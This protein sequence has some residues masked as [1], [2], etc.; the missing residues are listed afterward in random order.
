MFEKINQRV[1][2]KQLH[3]HLNQNILVVSASEQQGM[4]LVKDIL[5]A[6]ADKKTAL[7]LS[8]GRTP[9]ELY[10]V[11]AKEE[12][13][14]VGCV[15]MI[16]ERY[17]EKFHSNSNETMLRDAGLLRYLQMRDI[18][19]YPILQRK[20][21]TDSGLS[22]NDKIREN[23]ALQYDDQL[24]SL[25]AVYQKSIGILGIGLDGHTAGLPANPVRSEKR[26][27]R[28]SV[29]ARRSE[30]GK[31]QSEKLHDSYSFIASYH[32]EGGF[33]G[34]RITMTFLGLSMLDLLIV[35]VFG[36]A[37]Q[38]AL[39]LM[40]GEGKEEGVPSRFFKRPEIAAKTLLITDQNV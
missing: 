21:H 27:P 24:R 3:S 25:F 28:A 23:T 11:L 9:K 12:L 22:Q 20:I 35:L 26:S 30:V 1:T 4:D 38:N 8:G 36:S 19:F 13:L 34:K 16:D 29:D 10:S 6:V 14:D 17:G 32:D 33:Y 15:G 37:K 7:F 5:Y 31:V 2:V 40:F 39:E 18:P